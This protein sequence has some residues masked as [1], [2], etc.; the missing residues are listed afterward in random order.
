MPA[1]K[2]PI[3]ELKRKLLMLM[4]TL[5][6][7]GTVPGWIL[8]ESLHQSSTVLR[9]VFALNMVF[10]PVM[11]VM[12]W[13]RYVPQRVIEFSCLLFAAIICA[14]CMAVTLYSP[15]YGAS[16]DLEP[17]Y[18][19]IPI[20]YVFAFTLF[21]HRSSLKL[22]L[23]IMTLFFVV[24]LPFILRP[25]HVQ[26]FTITLHV[27]SAAL[28]AALY[29]FSGYQHSFQ[30]AQ[31]T[32]DELARMANTD[33]LTGLA[34]R[35]RVTEVIESELHRSL[36]YGHCFSIILLDIDYFKS[37]NDGLGHVVGDQVLKALARRVCESVR[38]VDIVGRWGG[39]EFIVVLPETSFE[40]G[41]ERAT[42]LCRQVVATPLLDDHSVSISCGVA[43]TQGNDSLST[44]FHQADAALYKAKRN[45]RN[46][47]VGMPPEVLENLDKTL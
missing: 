15:V 2:L 29:F 17:L 4:L 28:V 20:I 9:G 13:K 37:I 32:M 33:D 1:T 43:T 16:M 27:V 41:L 44:M 11:F 24:S 46:C 30:V 6:W 10:H 18:L 35:R 25:S 7:L 21:D 38:E 22:S 12:A 8:K 40:V 45:G 39:E 36:R 14:G 19:W 26:V 47:A 42:R 3:E 31:L 5:A 23:G 34:N